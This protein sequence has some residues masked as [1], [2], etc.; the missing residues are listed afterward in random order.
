MDKLVGIVCVGMPGEE[1]ERHPAI[2][3]YVVCRRRHARQ[4]A[5]AGREAHQAAGASCVAKAVSGTN[6]KR[7][8]VMVARMDVFYFAWPS[9]LASG[10]LLLLT[11]AATN[12]NEAHDACTDAEYGEG[13]RFRHGSGR[14]A[15]F[16]ASV[17]NSWTTCRLTERN[18]RCTA[19]R[20]G[21]VGVTVELVRTCP[22]RILMFPTARCVDGDT[23]NAESKR[24]IRDVEL[25]WIIDAR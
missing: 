24:K 13:R 20:L 22:V 21:K 4:A 19:E 10:G 5:L 17:P 1:I 6:E 2:P 23:R 25:R 14:S 18:I 16:D 15:V 9:A 8:T 11:S 3:L 12:G 7:A